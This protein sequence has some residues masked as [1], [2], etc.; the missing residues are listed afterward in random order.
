MKKKFIERIIIR[1]IYEF[2]SC[3]E[4]IKVIEIKKG[5]E[6]REIFFRM[7]CCFLREK[8]FVIVCKMMDYNIFF[9]KE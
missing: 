6:K 8:Y 2:I 4:Y 1:L 7:S 3:S 9:N 5:K